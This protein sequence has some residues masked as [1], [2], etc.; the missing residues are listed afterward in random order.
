MARF[1]RLEE[2]VVA[3]DTRVAAIESHLSALDTRVAALEARQSTTQ[4]TLAHLSLPAPLTPAPTPTPHVELSGVLRQAEHPAAPPPE[5]PPDTIPSVLALQEPLA[6]VKLRDHTS[7]HPPS[8]AHPNV[9]TLV[10]RNLTAVLHQLN[11]P[12]KAASAPLL[13]VLRKALSCAG[14]NALIADRDRFR[15]IRL[16]NSSSSALTGLSAWTETP[17]ADVRSATSTIPAAPHS[18]TADSRLLH[19]W[20]AYHAVHRRWQTQKHNR[21]LRLRLARLASEMEEHC[22]LLR[23]HCWL[24]LSQGASYTTTVPVCACV[25][26]QLFFLSAAFCCARPRRNLSSGH[27]QR[28][29]WEIER[30]PPSERISNQSGV[31]L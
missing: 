26:L 9:A 28:A 22:S 29:R 11:S 17:L 12:P 18:S 7:C 24:D 19:L 23:Q 15:S 2:R 30:L 4:A 13:L 27:F 20:E 3:I 8:E 6:P 21:R 5:Y 25:L 16:T 31:S 1:A 10:H 14:R